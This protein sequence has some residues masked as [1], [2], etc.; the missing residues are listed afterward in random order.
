MLQFVLRDRNPRKDLLIFS[1]PLIKV[2]NDN[3][4]KFLVTK[5]LSNFVKNNMFQIITSNV[6]F[7]CGR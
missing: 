7:T 6:I 3:T 5:C 1:Q 2:N 4:I